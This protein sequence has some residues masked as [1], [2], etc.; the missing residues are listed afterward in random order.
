M[1]RIF[2]RQVRKTTALIGAAGL[3]L[4]LAA[5]SPPNENPSDIKVDTAT[6]FNAPESEDDAAISGT[7]T[8]NPAGL[9][10]PTDTTGIDGTDGT[11]GSVDPS[12]NGEFDETQPNPAG[13]ETASVQPNL[14]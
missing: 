6:E 8:T 12:V 5:C 4:A 10:E 3:A 13:V 7:E 9:V 14:G 1:N 11:D 2:T